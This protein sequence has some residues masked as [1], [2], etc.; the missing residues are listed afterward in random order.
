MG[1][2]LV[3][4]VV[5]AVQFPQGHFLTASAL[6]SSPVNSALF[7]PVDIYC[8]RL[9]PSFWAEPFNAVTNA[10]FLIAAWFAWRLIGHRH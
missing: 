10:S 9:G 2:A 1:A 4:P 7:T 3:G 8:E 5:R 6:A